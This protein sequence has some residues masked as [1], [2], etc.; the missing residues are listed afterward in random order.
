MQVPADLRYSADHG[1]AAARAEVVRVGVT[2]YAQDAIGE[3]RF[4]Q[5]PE[6][7]HRVTAGQLLGEVE[8]SKSVSEIYA[9]VAGVVCAVNRALVEDPALVNRDPYGGGWICELTPDDGDAV[10]ALLD[11]TA[12]RALT[13]D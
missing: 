13:E 12:Y 10:A 5:L 3:L 7:G 8:S 4:V 6:I 9:P 1:W 11:A 2:E